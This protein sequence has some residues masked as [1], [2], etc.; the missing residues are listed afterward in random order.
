MQSVMWAS[1]FSR[2]VTGACAAGFEFMT[3]LPRMSNAIA[4]CGAFYQS[5]PGG[6]SGLALCRQG[7]TYLSDSPPPAMTVSCSSVEGTLR[8][9]ACPRGI[10]MK[11]VWWMLGDLAGRAA[12]P[13]TN[14]VETQWA[15]RRKFGLECQDGACDPLDG[16]RSLNIENGCDSHSRFAA[17]G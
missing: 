2:S 7:D 8:R 15:C 9:H 6:S 10:S 1:S 4:M 3:H 13:L 5:H 16:M 17:D 14:S 11:A 12:D